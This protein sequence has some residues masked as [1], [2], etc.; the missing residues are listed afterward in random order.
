LGWAAPGEAAEMME[1]LTSLSQEIDYNLA[2]T[3]AIL[4][5]LVKVP[6]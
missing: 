3:W 5:N 1:K 2:K 6:N 4:A